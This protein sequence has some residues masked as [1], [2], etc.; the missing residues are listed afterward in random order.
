MQDYKLP[1]DDY[2]K[3]IVLTGDI[4]KA[5]S[6]VEA[7]R[8]QGC[9]IYDNILDA[10]DAAAG[11][12]V[13]AV[14]VIISG[15]SGRLKTALG[16]LRDVNSRA[17]IILLAQTYE[18]PAA[19]QLVD[20][21][22]NGAGLADD[23][24]ICPIRFA[25]VVSYVSG[26]A[27]GTIDDIKD[28]KSVGLDGRDVEAKLAL[29]LKTLEKLATTDELT[30]LKNRRYIWEFCRQVIQRGKR[31]NGRV[32]LLIFDIDN[33]K[34]YN[35]VYGHSAGD[36]VLR[37]AGLLMQRCCRRHDVVARVG[38][39]EFVVVFW[40]ERQLEALGSATE[41]RSATTDHP[42]EVIFIAKRFR[43]ELKKT[44]FHLLGTEGKGVL[45]ISG[46]LAGFPRDGST[47]E[48]LFEQADKALLEAKS[49]GKNR[50][51]LVGRPES[52]ITDIE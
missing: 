32:T 12:N 24:L 49:R 3:E 40:D 43:K 7:V 5:F 23:Y 31:A 38:G 17:K 41:R 13:S 28:I 44:E 47:V 9:E 6:D 14:F 1:S 35:D 26:G 4:E 19:M 16:A 50:I 27:T 11:R 36:K 15:L 21:T 39:D 46:G 33:F 29:K 52:D 10:I 18:E 25:D 37:Q 51:Y 30:G 20:S 2:R 48:E 42:K 34:H 22:S 8:R 45:T